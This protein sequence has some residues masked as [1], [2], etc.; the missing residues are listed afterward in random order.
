M[1]TAVLLLVKKSE[2][3]YI[4]LKNW[5]NILY[6]LYLNIITQSICYH[7]HNVSIIHTHIIKQMVKDVVHFRTNKSKMFNRK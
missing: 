5:L 4:S 1:F 2:K 3:N 6:I 7:Y